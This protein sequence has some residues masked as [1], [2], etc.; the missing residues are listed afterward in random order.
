MIN[1][2]TKVLVDR[3]E[4]WMFRPYQ[5]SEEKVQAEILEM[6]DVPMEGL[7]NS[8]HL[9]EEYNN[10]LLDIEKMYEKNKF[11]Y[12]HIER[13]QI[14]KV[15]NQM[16]T[17]VLNNMIA[18][19]LIPAA[20]KLVQSVKPTAKSVWDNTLLPATDK[21]LRFLTKVFVKTKTRISEI[22]EEET[23]SENNQ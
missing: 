9:S 16:K 3:L 5:K 2:D 7:L 15:I 21:S 6:F 20:T 1:P 10:F 12:S 19:K 13:R 18:D 23:K 17:P 22:S 4:Y 14:E 11:K 8:D